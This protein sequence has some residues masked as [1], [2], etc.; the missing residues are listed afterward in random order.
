MFSDASR[1]NL[2]DYVSNAG[3]SLVFLTAGQNS[4]PISWISYNT[5]RKVSSTL[6]ADDDLN[7]AVYLD[8]LI[9]EIYHGNVEDSK[10]PVVLLINNNLG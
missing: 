9:T 6:C 8:H 3:E 4:C 2:P 7:D 1:E 10:T 5:R